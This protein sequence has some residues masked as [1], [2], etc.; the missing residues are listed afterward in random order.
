LRYVG[1]LRK[2]VGTVDVAIEIEL[3]RD[4]RKAKRISRRDLRYGRDLPET[5]F[6]RRGDA[7]GHGLGTGTWHLR[8]DENGGEVDL[9]QRCNWQPRKGDQAQERNTH[10]EQCCGDGAGDKG[11]G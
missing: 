3:Q 11:R 10:R 9:G 5:A 2:L 8:L 7:G 1:L 4:T 6:E